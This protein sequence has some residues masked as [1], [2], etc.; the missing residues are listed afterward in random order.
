[1]NGKRTILI[2]DDEPDIVKILKFR[3]ERKGYAVLVAY[4]GESGLKLANESEPGLIILDINIPKIGGIEFYNKICTKHGRSKYPVLVLTAR[5]E[6]KDI[7]KDIQADGFM[8]KPFEI[9]V[10]LKEIDRILSGAS[11]PIVFLMDFKDNPR[12]QEI[13]KALTKERYKV[14]IV[15]TIEMFKDEAIRKKPDF[16]LMEYIQADK[17][18]D[19][20]IAKIK[21]IP[22]TLSETVWPSSPKVP[23]IV[24]SYSGLDY[25]DKSLEA[26]ADKYIGK[27]EQYEDFVRAIEEFRIKKGL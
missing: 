16:I 11:D 3:L 5:G 23:I 8:S 7:F 19:E 17:S 24:Y 21:E 12:T 1:V 26:G 6:L 2:I 25:K 27:P 13:Q 20:I 15:E 14:V 10:L 22:S 4:D 9:D 18:G